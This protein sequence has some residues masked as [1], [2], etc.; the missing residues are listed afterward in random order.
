MGATRILI[1][2]GDTDSRTVYRILLQHHG[3]E[4]LETSSGTEALALVRSGDVAV[5]VTELTLRD[6]NGLALLHAIR[7][8]PALERLPV[9]VLTARGFAED[10][11]RAERA[12]CTRFLL[13]PLEPNELARQIR[14]L[15]ESGAAT[16]GPG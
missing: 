8:D 6:G 9:L 4:V 10:R 16:R 5:V 3:L 15:L 7:S 13:K 1:A 12:G 2:D 14:D 11:E